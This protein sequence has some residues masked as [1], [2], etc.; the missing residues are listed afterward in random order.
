MLRVKGCSL[1]HFTQ[2]Q[3]RRANTHH[4]VVKPRL[5]R[6][7]SP[8]LRHRVTVTPAQRPPAHA[9]GHCAPQRCAPPPLPPCPPAP[10]TLNASTES[11]LK[12]RQG[13]AKPSLKPV[14]NL[15]LSSGA[16]YGSSS[17]DSSSEG[18]AP[19]PREAWRERG[20]KEG[21]QGRIR[22]RFQLWAANLCL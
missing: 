9:D 2:G 10:P 15:A 13:S 17:A 16:T 18:K 3:H 8:G 7:P 5:S 21:R 11:F 6:L 22:G 4:K 20:R 14:Q 1:T 12:R 19:A